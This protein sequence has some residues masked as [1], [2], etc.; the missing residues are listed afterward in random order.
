MIDCV[1][2]DI[3]RLVPVADSIYINVNFEIE[4]CDGADF[5][6]GGHLP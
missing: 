1:W 2:Y 3:Q 6:Q 4:R 5:Q